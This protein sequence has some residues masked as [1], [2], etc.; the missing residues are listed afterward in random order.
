MCEFFP[1]ASLGRRYMSLKSAVKQNKEQEKRLR[2]LK[3]YAHLNFMVNMLF[4]KKEK[5]LG[6]ASV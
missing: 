1:F 6:E 4:S 2:F 5:V 3:N